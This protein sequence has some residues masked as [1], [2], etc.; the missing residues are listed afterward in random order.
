MVLYLNCYTWEDEEW[1]YIHQRC[2]HPVRRRRL[3]R[4]DHEQSDRWGLCNS[5]QRR[6]LKLRGSHRSGIVKLRFS[7]KIMRNSIDTK[8][9][10][11]LFNY[12][13][14]NSGQSIIIRPLFFF[15]RS[16]LLLTLPMF[17]LYQVVG[18]A[19]LLLTVAAVGHNKN[20]RVSS[21]LGPLIVAAVVMAIGICF[22]HNAGW[23]RNEWQVLANLIDLWRSDR[24]V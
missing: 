4:R 5:S 21:V 2:L 7:C 18:T 12:D 24:S 13:R 22:G 17:P 19:L 10:F 6:H 3:E 1:I 9:P 16:W 8:S 11:F 15:L 23:V 20:E 14:D